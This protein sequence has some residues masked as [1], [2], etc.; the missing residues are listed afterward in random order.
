MLTLALRDLQYRKWRVVVVAVLMSIVVMLLFVMTGLVNQFNQ[1]P[2]LATERS[3]GN[4]SWLV[5]ETSTGPLTSPSAAPQGAVDDI[6]GA[7]PILIGMASLNGERVS[8]VGRAN[9]IDEPVIIDGRYPESDGEVLVD[10]S[11]GWDVGDVV[12]LGGSQAT[13]VG[14]TSDATVLAG[15]P[16][17]FAQLQYA[18][19][20]LVAGQPIVTGALLDRPVEPMPTG[21]KELSPTDVGDDGL[22]PLDGAIASIGLSRSR[23]SRRP[24]SKSKRNT[25]RLL[26]TKVLSKSATRASPAITSP[27]TPS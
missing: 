9:A 24:T 27:V 10:E 14:T 17:I 5:A 22:V 23:C 15:V 2:F 3:G 4:R 11:G 18:Q 8:L 16:M 19:Q 20:V 7:E 26:S 21:M 6:P 12:D 25:A 13:V 1:E